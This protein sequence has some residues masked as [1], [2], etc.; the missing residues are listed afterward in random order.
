MA[1]E[2]HYLKGDEE[3]GP[4]S[5][6]ELKALASSGELSPADML[7][8]V[9]MDEWKPA[10]GLKGLFITTD[11]AMPPAIQKSPTPSIEYATQSSHSTK[12]RHEKSADVSS[13]RNE[14]ALNTSSNVNSGTLQK[15][16]GRP[17]FD[18]RHKYSRGIV[19]LAAGAISVSLI[20]SV[21]SA[22]SLQFLNILLTFQYALL[23]LMLPLAI[24]FRVIDSLRG[25]SF[26]SRKQ[27][28]VGV[29]ICA[30]IALL[31]QVSTGYLQATFGWL[32]FL[33]LVCRV[34]LTTLILLPLPRHLERSLLPFVALFV[35]G[36]LLY[37]SCRNSW[38]IYSNLTAL[39]KEPLQLSRNILSILEK[40]MTAAA[41]IWYYLWNSD[42]KWANSVLNTCANASNRLKAL[43]V[44]SPV[45]V[46]SAESESG[47]KKMLASL[48]ASAGAAAAIMSLQTERT[49]LT[50]MSLPAAY[51]SLGKDCVQQKRH[52]DGVA[53]L[54]EQL[55][56][57]MS[58]IKAL[59]DAASDQPAAQS[60]TDKAKAA[61]KQALDLARQKQLGM[62]RDSLITSI[63]KA[64]HNQHADESGP[65]VVVTPIR[66]AL[67]R[68]SQLDADIVR[69]S[70]VEKGAVLTP[71]RLLAA[72]A[73][74][75]LIVVVMS[76]NWLI[77][78]NSKTL[79]DGAI[80]STLGADNAISPA[81]GPDLE[82]LAQLDTTIEELDLRETPVT[83][84]VTDI[85][86]LSA[87]QHLKVLYTPPLPPDQFKI[88]AALPNLESLSCYIKRSYGENRDTTSL[89]LALSYLSESKTLKNLQVRRWRDCG[90]S[91]DSFKSIKD[92]PALTCLEVA[93]FQLQDSNLASIGN[94]NT[95]TTLVLGGTGLITSN[96]INALA[97]CRSLNYLEMGLLTTSS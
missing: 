77:S 62:K 75:G 65:A 93:Y 30:A 14:V 1:V 43:F 87:F 9:G 48:S 92:F 52:L 27:V 23:Q 42:S 5:T 10:S 97:T 33:E 19:V 64:I 85:S 8:K 26:L 4:V 31:I 7:W 51:R 11:S 88:I 34:A 66:E 50:S 90:I 13:Q 18:N 68:I 95:I 67:A 81:G 78:G 6:S 32:S 45:V 53:D 60:F 44:V 96:G 24:I 55:R 28:L 72:V 2:W 83:D 63:G 82:S 17:S 80:S 22:R 41:V 61:G 40:S 12:N 73:V 35:C 89:H 15:A 54:V 58:D 84:T 76:A 39:T 16:S 49:K 71:K 86:H 69:Q 57:V 25:V 46:D 70:D 20:I 74:V 21:D 38:L 79:S 94:S 56:S 59:S 91:D 47:A 29:V 3:Y 36:I 37:V